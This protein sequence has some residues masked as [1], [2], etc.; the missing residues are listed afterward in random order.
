[1]INNKTG[2]WTGGSAKFPWNPNG[3]MAV[4]GERGQ[5]NANRLVVAEFPTLPPSSPLYYENPDQDL[6]CQTITPSWAP[7]LEDY[8]LLEGGRYTIASPLGGQ[9]VLD[10]AVAGMLGAS[11]RIVYENYTTRNGTVVNGYGQLRTSLKTLSQNASLALTL[12]GNTSGS[13]TYNSTVAL[14]QTARVICG[15]AASTVDGVKR[16]THQ[17]EWNPACHFPMPGE[18]PNGADAD[19]TPRG[20]GGNF[21][22]PWACEGSYSM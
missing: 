10:L 18:C 17:G 3:T 2:G 16:V 14:R 22:L 13:G 1:M 7:L 5:N 12:S 8:P 6:A 20:Q 19:A 9:A 11:N 4:W 15:V 21:S